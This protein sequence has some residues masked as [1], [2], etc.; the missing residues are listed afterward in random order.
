MPSIAS[1]YRGAAADEKIASSV[2]NEDGNKLTQG[3]LARARD[4]MIA[5]AAKVKVAPEELEQRTAEMFNEAVL[6]AA[7]AAAN[8]K[9]HVKFDFFLM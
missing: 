1:L 9:K 7:S 2:R 6:V 3:A 8:P 5:L 4:E